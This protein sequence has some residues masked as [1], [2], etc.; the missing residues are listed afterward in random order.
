MAMSR[1]DAIQ[2]AM[3]RHDLD[4]LLLGGEGAGQF[5][6]GHSRIGVHN[7]GSPIPVTVVPSTGSPHIVTVD[8]D[9]AVGMPPDHVHGMIWDPAVLVEQLPDWVGP[10]SDLRIGVDALSPGGRA[11]VSAA[12]P[13]STLVDATRLLAEVMLAKTPEEIEAMAD[14]CRLVTSAAEIG[15]QEGRPAMYRALQGAF[16]IA[17]PLISPER[18]H[19]AV[20]RVGLVA[21]ARLG[22]GDSRRGERAIEALSAGA[23]TSEVAAALPPGVEVVG[24]GR[25]YE[26][27]LIRDGRALPEELEL[28]AGA[29]LA[30]RWDGCGVTVAVGS[31]GP[32]LLSRTPEEVAR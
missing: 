32:R 28:V 12:L 10:G 8:P 11:L 24:I 4:A 6:A 9:G 14:L 15:R 16:P 21:E 29:V 1:L 2:L 22:R 23:A 20:R 25:S 30:V 31:D 7:P 17:Y 5:A 19:V 27:P 13:G 26:A 3:K 18:V